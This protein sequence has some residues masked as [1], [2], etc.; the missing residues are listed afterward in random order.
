VQI[1]GSR[2]LWREPANQSRIMSSRILDEFARCNFAAAVESV[3][4]VA[5][6]F[7]FGTTATL[8]FVFVVLAFF[9]GT[10]ATLFLFL[11]RHSFPRLTF[12]FEWWSLETKTRHSF[13]RFSFC[14]E[15][16]SNHLK[17]FQACREVM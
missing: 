3:V 13:P 5:S 16:W 6:A 10:K 12:C 14:F 1:D 9:F 15:W 7:P 2:G 11:S 17:L 4:L 8:A